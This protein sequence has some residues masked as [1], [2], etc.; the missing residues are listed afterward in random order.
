[1]RKLFASIAAMA[2]LTAPASAQL[3]T[4]HNQNNHNS[5]TGTNS[6]SYDPMY[7]YLDDQVADDFSVPG[8]IIWTIKKVVV[9]GQY[10][11]GVG[12][13]TS[14]NV[15]FYNDAGGL[16]GTLIAACMNRNG[17]SIGAGSFRIP[18]GSCGPTLTGAQR[19]WISVQAN[20]PASG[21]EWMWTNRTTVSGDPAVWEDPGLGYSYP[22]PCPTW[23]T[24]TVCIPGANG[25]DHM[26]KLIGTP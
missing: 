18:L 17:V 14:E 26:F 9:T 7:S 2:A 6:Q 4:L 5:G 21:G 23:N 12:P 25:G 24:E 16:P 3:V 20:M 1:M 8:G 13:A 22:T 11:N 10:F 19:Y 15:Y